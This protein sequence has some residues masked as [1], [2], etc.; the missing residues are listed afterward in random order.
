MK[1]VCTFVLFMAYLSAY[2]SEPIGVEPTNIP[3]TTTTTTIE[4]N[5]LKT[6][7]KDRKMVRVYRRAN[8]KVKK[9]L[10]FITKI[11]TKVA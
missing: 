4:S 11:K 1:T 5:T 3:L 6:S 9:E 7:L 10:F 8:S 2:G